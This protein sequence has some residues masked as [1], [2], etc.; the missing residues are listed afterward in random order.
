[1][2]RHR[3]LS[4]LLLVV[5]SVTTLVPSIPGEA[6]AQG[7]GKA[8]APAPAPPP[9]PSPAAPTAAAPAGDLISRGR[10]LFDDQQYEES[11]QVLSAALVRPSNTKEQRI[12]IHRLLAFNYI[13]LGRR[14]EAESAIRGLLSLEPDYALPTSESPRFRDFFKMVKEKWD[15]EG[16]PGLVVDTTT[17]DPV[18]LLHTPRSETEAGQLLPISVR[19]DDP[20]DRIRTIK[21]FYRTGSRGA[22]QQLEAEIRGKGARAVVPGPAVQPPFV[23]YYV[24]ALDAGGQPIAGRGDGTAPLRVVVPESGKGWVVPVVIGGSLVAVA[25]VFGGLALAGVFKSSPPTN[26][27]PGSRDATVSVTIRE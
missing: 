9:A 6:W 22:Y 26:Q 5:F 21:V 10:T 27:P 11:I 25:A 8:P 19:L 12:E 4:S 16:R 23:D 24:T 15:A 18:S 20:G 7:R 1:M 14:D 2:R 3:L 17:P 13:T